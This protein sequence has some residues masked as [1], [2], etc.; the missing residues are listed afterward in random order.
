[1]TTDANTRED[2]IEYILSNM[3][4]LSTDKIQ[5]LYTE[6]KYSLDN[7]GDAILWARYNVVLCMVNK[8][9]ERLHRPVIYSLFKF[10]KIPKED[11]YNVSADDAFINDLY[12]ILVPVFTP[13]QL[14]WG[15][16][17]RKN[18]CKCLYLLKRT[19][20]FIGIRIDTTM[21]RQK[22]NG[23]CTHRTYYTLVPE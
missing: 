19:C 1:M 16:D 22:R 4:T 9:F 18:K 2:K 13:Q 6:T 7:A 23:I 8:I 20:K 14:E 15:K 12:N 5:F 21:S 10:V 11:L 3:N 17:L